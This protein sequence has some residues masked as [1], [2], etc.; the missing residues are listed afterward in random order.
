MKIFISI[1]NKSLNLFKK[2]ME[3]KNINFCY[4][5]EKN[6]ILNNLNL[7]IEKNDILGIY[8]ETGSKIQWFL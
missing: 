3:L 6:L 2:N 8:G 1:V 4:H 5:D 7:K